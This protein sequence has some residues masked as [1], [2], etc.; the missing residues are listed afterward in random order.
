MGSALQLLASTGLRIGE[1]LGLTWQDVRFAERTLRVRGQG[2]ETTKGHRRVVPMGQALARALA[3]HRESVLAGAHD[4]VFPRPFSAQAAVRLLA[5]V[6]E[7]PLY[8]ISGGLSR[9]TRWRAV[10]RWLAFSGGGAT[11]LRQ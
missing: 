6:A 11:G 1:A 7:R 8:T 2:V 5:R 4:P 3:R 10:F 9:F